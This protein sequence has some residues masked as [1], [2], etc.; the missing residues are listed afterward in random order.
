MADA[1]PAQ[2]AMDR[3]QPAAPV[4]TMGEFTALTGLEIEQIWVWKSCL[5]LVFDLGAPDQHGVYIDLTDFRFKDTAS[6]EWEVRVEDDPL[7]AGP[8]L[9]LLNHLLKLNRDIGRTVTQNSQF[10]GGVLGTGSSVGRY[11]RRS[12]STCGRAVE[13]DGALEVGYALI[14]AMAEEGLS[15]RT[16]SRVLECRN[17]ASTTGNHARRRNGRSITPGRS[18][19]TP[20]SISA[21]AVPTAVVGCTPSCVRGAASWSST[22]Q[23]HSSPCSTT[24]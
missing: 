16:G 12:K 7:T 21:P 6:Q 13:R 24:E 18:G 3:L 15:I 5:R 19:R 1:L 9:G 17:P 14:S 23:S 11:R 2:S 4:V 10:M 22:A 20:K 8:V